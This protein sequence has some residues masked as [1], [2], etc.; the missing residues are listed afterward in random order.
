MTKKFKIILGYAPPTV[1]HYW[2]QHGVRRF[3]SKRANTFRHDIK[4]HCKDKRLEGF[5]SVHID[6]YPPDKR[7][8]DIDNIIKPILD[9]LQH[10]ELFEDDYQ[11]KK[12]SAN[13]LETITGGSCVI[14]ITELVD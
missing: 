14:T 10:A 1:N 7:K 2:L 4:G 5:L 3:L 12:I 11:V 13:R 6:Y 8:R 9:A